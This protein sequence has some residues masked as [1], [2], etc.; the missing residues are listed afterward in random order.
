MIFDPLIPVQWVVV[1]GV[2]MLCAAIFFQLRSGRRLGRWRSG[3]LLVVRVVALG[4][5]VFL[6][7][8]PSREEKVALPKREKSVLF[9]VDD[10]AS[11]AEAHEGGA[12]R[13][14][15]ARADLEAAG[16]LGDT[17]RDLRFFR[18]A[19]TGEEIGWEDLR[20]LRPEGEDTQFD[21]SVAAI[22]RVARQPPPA[23]LVVLSDGHDF[24]L[25]SPGETA[26]RARSR[27][28]PIYTVA[29]G[30][31]E[32]ARDVSVGIANYHPHTF[33]R[34]R[35]NLE[36]YLRTFG[37]GDEQIE[38]DLL[39][40]GEKVDSKVVDSGK[41]SYHQVR[42][43]V[44][45]EEPGQFE[46]TFRVAPV[47]GERELSNN[48]ATTYLNVIS[49]RIRILEVEGRPFWDSTF[50]R[51]SFARN[52]KFDIDSLVAFTGERV[53]PIRSNPSR[54]EEDL[55]PP[56]R[57]EDLEPY[58][59]VILG[60]EVERVIGLDGIRAIEEWVEDRGGIVVFSRGRAWAQGAKVAEGLE[61]I[62]WE[63]G[64]G[65]G[66]RLQ[67]TPQAGGVSAFQL[68]R[69]TAAQDGFPEV[70]G[71]AGGD[72]KPL[73]TTFSVGGDQAPAIVYRR[74]GTGQTMSLG[75]GNLWRW[76]FNPKAEYDNNAYDRFWDQLA[77]WLLSNGGV[78]PSEGY[79]LRSDTVNLPVGEAINF[80]FGAQG[81]DLPAELPELEITLE[82]QR[83]T[84][85]ALQREGKR[86]EATG[87]FSPQAPGRYKARVV[88]PDGEEVSV[89]FIVFQAD[90][91]RIETAMDKG[92][93]E[94]L[95]RA[96]GGRAIGAEEIG[97]VV[98][99]L[100]HDSADQEPLVKR[101]SLWDR[102]WVFFV[103][104]SLFGSEWYLRRRW[105]LT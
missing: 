4:A 76:V 99:N 14:D 57:V 27:D 67:V 80:Y 60:R 92:Y 82:D 16:V 85:L 88:L 40:D 38:V 69:E 105:G 10:S 77:L 96:S 5:V 103:L 62:S 44:V 63:E 7:L 13:L 83:V 84:Q 97:E 98:A 12:T 53:R 1:V 73:A 39:R 11:M 90:R 65:R 36:A 24:E 6:L 74:F 95:A 25:V 9:A 29:Y 102:G 8:Q 32:N 91:E 87:G 70:V 17:E 86:K 22:L 34:Q 64:T 54:A 45:H 30:T 43:S 94:E 23:G 21:R 49:E 48:R 100:L 75:V 58:D 56:A 66:T 78:T 72:P 71:F 2:V 28:F 93:L 51:R 52:D 59:L 46:Y 26:S 19:G 89:R 31:M 61:P 68:L 42:F 35:T 41:S 20:E 55:L 18:F 15:A 104:C 50:L 37:V 3:L 33:I 101:V 81:V 79:S 47:V